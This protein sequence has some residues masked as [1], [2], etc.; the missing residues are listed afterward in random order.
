[1]PPN[2]AR[3]RMDDQRKDHIDTKEPKQRNLP[4]PLQTHN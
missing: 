1:M 2:S 4:K 3:T